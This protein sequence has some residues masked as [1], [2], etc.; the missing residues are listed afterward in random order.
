MLAE[1]DYSLTEQAH[2]GES[3]RFIGDE[4]LLV[5]FDYRPKHNQT[6]SAEA[7]RPIFEEVAYITIM[8]PGNKDSIVE[9][10]ANEMD[11]QR[12]PKHWQ[13]FEARQSQDHVEGTLL[14]Q[15]PAL[16]RSQ[17][18]ELKY[19]NIRTLEQLVAM[20]DSNAQGIMGIQA[21][22]TKAKAYLEAAD[23]QAAA[24]ELAERD[25]K[26]DQLLKANEAL[27]ERVE[28]LEAEAD[29]D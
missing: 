11:K 13:K 23:I 3:G 16:T 9:R 29:E 6:K 25:A 21:L 2:Q 14:E 7:G 24:E 10:P 19:L 12:F 22:R 8:Q 28:K 27:M 26:I 5:K 15:W 20:S 4:T 1:A 18:E 17:V